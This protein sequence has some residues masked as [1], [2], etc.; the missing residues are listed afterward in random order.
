MTSKNVHSLNT[1]F[2][3]AYKLIGFAILV[4]MLAGLVSYLGIN[5]FYFVDRTWA[6]PAILSPT[7]VRVLQLRQQIAQHR[8]ERDRLMAQRAE[9]AARLS[10]A[11]RSGAALEELKATFGATVQADAAARRADLQKM[12]RLQ[13]DIRRTRAEIDLSSGAYGELTRRRLQNERDAHIIDQEAYLSGNYQLAQMARSK[14]SQAE[15]EV[16]V[17]SRASSLEREARA[18]AAVDRRGGG[19]LTYDA[20]RVKQ[21][22]H[23]TLLEL[24]RA[25]E[26]EAALRQSIEAIDR[27]I[28]SADAMLQTFP[29]SPF[30]GA[31][32]HDLNA[33]YVP[34]ENVGG[35]QKGAPLY[36]CRLGILFCKRVGHV[37]EVFD[38]EVTVNHPLH[39]KA[40]RGVMIAVELEGERRWMQQ[41]VLFAGRPPLLL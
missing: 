25:R 9:V 22:L 1:L 33:A 20:L 29:R 10:D 38:T 23:R 39:P 19:E 12:S 36:G 8:G 21:D 34:Y 26:M 41:A 6:A 17:E 11:V 2:V 3:S 16:M 28:A 13:G 15:T 40:L 5:L 32:E 27:S 31:I 18:L 30:F 37:R 7:D 4:A 24:A 35:V 14:L